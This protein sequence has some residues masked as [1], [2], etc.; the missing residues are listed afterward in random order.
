VFVKGHYKHRTLFCKPSPNSHSGLIR[1]W[2]DKKGRY[3]LGA[4]DAHGI[5]V[6]SEFEVYLNVSSDNLGQPYGT[7]RVKGTSYLK[8]E[9]HPRGDTRGEIEPKFGYAFQVGYFGVRVHLTAEVRA[10]I[11]GDML[12]RLQTQV[13]IVAEKR[14]AD[15]LVEVG[16]DGQDIIVYSHHLAGYTFPGI[17]LQGPATVPGALHSMA[18][19]HWSISYPEPKQSDRSGVQLEFFRLQRVYDSMGIPSREPVGTNLIENGV[20]H[21]PEEELLYGL[22]IINKSE[23]DLYLYIFLWSASDQSIRKHAGGVSL[24]PY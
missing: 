20:V 3:M 9:L 12:R 7:M 6:G 19:W 17:I 8:A 1:A 13:S 18:H 5:V 14:D 10:L 23:I 11:S 4:G 21:L 2:K 24:D 15:L 22:N 16:Q